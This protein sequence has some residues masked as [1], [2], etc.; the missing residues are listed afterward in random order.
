[1]RDHMEQT[2]EKL[3]ALQQSQAA[4]KFHG[5]DRTFGRVLG[6]LKAVGWAF[7]GG[8]VWL[9]GDF[10]VN[11]S[12]GWLNFS[13]TVIA[14]AALI[15]CVWRAYRGIFHAPRMSEVV[16]DEVM[17]RV[18]PV[19]TGLGAAADLHNRFKRKSV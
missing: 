12:D 13:A 19:E 4:Q 2:L 17:D 6:V 5:A 10:T 18:R 8:C 15:Y 1:M 16:I 9:I 11:N 7:A 3:D 14:A